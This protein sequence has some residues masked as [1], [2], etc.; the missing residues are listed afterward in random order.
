MHCTHFFLHFKYFF[1]IF[2]QFLLKAAVE[3]N[4][5]LRWWC[6][7]LITIIITITITITITIIITV[8]IIID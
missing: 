2:I 7:A 4:A 8:I 3:Q 5:M 6:I 1:N